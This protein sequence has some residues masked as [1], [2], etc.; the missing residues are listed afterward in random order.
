MGHWEYWEDD[1][2]GRPGF[3]IARRELAW[4]LVG[5]VAGGMAFGAMIGI[6]IF[7]SHI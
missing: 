7:S 1:N 4:L 5:A 3:W 2:T 6:A